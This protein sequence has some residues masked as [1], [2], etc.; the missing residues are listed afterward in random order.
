MRSGESTRTPRM[1]S[2]FKSEPYAWIMSLLLVLSSAL[3]GFSPGIPHFPSPQK[4]TVPVEFQFDQKCETKNHFVD[5]LPLNCHN[6]FY[7]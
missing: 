6:Y 5:V 7:D 2:G 1:W 3:R 4:P